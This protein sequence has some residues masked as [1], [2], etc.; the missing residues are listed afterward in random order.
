MSSF[1]VKV[2]YLDGSTLSLEKNSFTQFI[3]LIEE[4]AQKNNRIPLKMVFS[5]GKT[6]YYDEEQVRLFVNQNIDQV[7]FIENTECDGI[8]RNTSKL[9]GDEPEEIEEGCLWCRKGNYM[10]LI[11]KDRN[12][13]CEFTDTCFIET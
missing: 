10:F 4:D 9:K 13:Y 12:M 5:T 8:Y 3:K 6:L 7:E 1:S 2:Y 11:D